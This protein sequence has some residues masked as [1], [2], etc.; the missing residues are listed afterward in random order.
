MY[1]FD[2]EEYTLETKKFEIMSIWT[3][4]MPDDKLIV[5]VLNNIFNRG[6]NRRIDF[7]Y[8]M[9]KEYGPRRI[10]FSI[11]T[12]LTM[13]KPFNYKKA[14]E[15]LKKN[16]EDE[17]DT[18][19]LLDNIIK[20]IGNP[21]HAYRTSSFIEND[22][23]LSSDR[24]FNYFI[25]LFPSETCA[26]SSMN[27]ETND[28]K[29]NAQV[30]NI[31]LKNN[32]MLTLMLKTTY[33][34]DSKEYE[35]NLH[36]MSQIMQFPLKNN[37]DLDAIWLLM[38]DK[39]IFNNSYEKINEYKRKHYFNRYGNHYSENEYQLQKYKCE[40]N[41][42]WNQYFSAIREDKRRATKFMTYIPDEVETG[43]SK[44]RKK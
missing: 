30:I 41:R 8:S 7:L 16:A 37:L 27:K 32:S 2:N 33:H 21:Q 1:R 3:E 35:Y 9:T 10:D 19:L 5:S 28:S 6:V 12:D 24:A 17:H 14:E 26:I 34:F 31:V 20:H 25:S 29:I 43:I 23:I 39:Y 42:C 40:V 4:F 36:A 22:F 18:W 13:K 15:L 38:S 11:L 44:T